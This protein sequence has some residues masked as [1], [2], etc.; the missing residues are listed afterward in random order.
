MAGQPVVCRMKAGDQF[1]GPEPCLKEFSIQT[2]SVPASLGIVYVLGILRSFLTGDTSP[3]ASSG[4]PF[5]PPWLRLQS[6]RML[7]PLKGHLQV[8]CEASPPRLVHLAGITP[9]PQVKCWGDL[10]SVECR[11]SICRKQGGNCLLEQFLGRKAGDT[12]A[13]LFRGQCKGV[14]VERIKKKK[15]GL[16]LSGDI[17]AKIWRF[18]LFESALKNLPI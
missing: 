7:Q 15:S 3:P 5:P 18:H 2:V 12:E 8:S 4:Q 14:P 17:A 9:A 13:E 11:L 10:R 6:F 1:K 16:L